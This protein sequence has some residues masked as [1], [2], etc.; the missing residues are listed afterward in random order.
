MNDASNSVPSHETTPS[1]NEQQQQGLWQRV[2]D[3]SPGTA[4]GATRSR[5]PRSSNIALA[6]SDDCS[7]SSGSDGGDSHRSLLTSTSSPLG[8][9]FARTSSSVSSLK[10]YQGSS[11]CYSDY[12]NNNNHHQHC[13]SNSII[14]RPSATSLVNMAILYHENSSSAVHAAQPQQSDAH[15]AASATHKSTR[16]QH[17]LKNR[18]SKPS[19]TMLYLRHR[20]SATNLSVLCVGI[21]LCVL[22]VHRTLYLYMNHRRWLNAPIT[23]MQRQCP[24]PQYELMTQQASN[25]Q[26][27]ATDTLQSTNNNAPS[28]CL[29]TFTDAQSP[30]WIQKLIR[31]RNYAGILE[32]T[33][34]NKLAYATKHNYQLFDHSR[35]L[36]TSR[37]PAWSKIPAMQALLQPMST[38]SSNN[39]GSASESSSQSSN[40]KHHASTKHQHQQQHAHC[41][42]VVWTDADTVIMNSNISITD[43]LPSADSGL[44]LVVASDEGG[45]YNSGVLL[46]RNTDWSRHFL[47]T[48]WDMTNY[49]RPPGF[50]LSGDN[51]AMK[52]LLR[53]LPDFDQHVAVPPRCVMN[54]FARFLTLRESKH[55]ME[56]LENQVWYMSESFYHRSDFIAHAPGYDN[57]A[58][59]IRLLL[60]EA[61]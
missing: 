38:S 18:R 23:Y 27:K 40:T 36:D 30:S 56:T 19:R 31:W 21:L 52:A 54:S 4:A 59:C 34:P 25:E 22:A 3:W 28:I 16:S 7:N 37:P 32:L 20:A 42:W 2:K 12:R 1:S 43:F 41:D 13:S 15:S 24:A 17:S 6:L 48:W 58:E 60:Q 49:V 11:S 53:D 47:Q 50:S 26:E 39:G 8:G 57:K 61:E 46:L 51:A 14:S 55:V 35:Y 29:V 9:V 45:G 33:W 5:R 44:D 10:D